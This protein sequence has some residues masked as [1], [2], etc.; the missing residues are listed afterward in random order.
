MRYLYLIL[1]IVVLAAPFLVRRAVIGPAP[2][3]S[4]GSERLVIVTP[5]NQDIRREFARAFDAWHREHYGTRVE[6][7]YRT[8]GGTS[9]IKRLL[10][11][12]YRPY[13]D[14]DGRIGDDVPAGLDIVWGGGDFYFNQELKP[15]GILEPMPIDPALLGKVFPQPALAGVRLYDATQKPDGTPTPQW[16]GLCL[17]SF[18]IIYNPELYD[19]MRLAAPGRWDDLTNTKLAGLIALADPSH[20]GSAAVAYMMVLQRAMA[21]AEENLFVLKPELKKLGK[22][23]RAANPAYDQAISAGWNRG[24]AQLLRIAANARYFTDS[25]SQVPTDVA[26][27]QAAAG[28]AIDFYAR[29]TEQSIGTSRAR[30]VAPKAATAI[31]P[32]PVAILKGVPPGRRA[33]A[34]QF[35]EF[36]LSTEGQRMWI[37]RPGVP[38]GPAEFPLCRSPIRRD[39]YADRR[40]WTDDTDPFNVSGGFNQRGEWMSLLT[41]ARVVWVAAWIDSRDALESAFGSILAVRDPSRRAQLLDELAAPAEPVVSMQE[42]KAVADERRR[43]EKQPGGDVDRWRALQRIEWSDRFRRHYNHVGGEARQRP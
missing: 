11:T 39:L 9:D 34:Q 40:G 2:H 30:F 42:I 5:H 20:S 8:P 43:R 41:D 7:D 14:A 4:G 19:T 12:T 18:G 35:V 26:N 15:L 21:D 1:F 32:D 36:L 17:S 24:M 3:P 23:E 13:R 28:M 25:A 6:L 27:G 29:V 38:G 33:L 10:E 16:I 31:T 37:L 22:A